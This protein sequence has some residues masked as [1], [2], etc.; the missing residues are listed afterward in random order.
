MLTKPSLPLAAMIAITLSAGIAT[1][2]YAGSHRPDDKAAIELLRKAMGPRGHN[3][4]FNHARAAFG[5]NRPKYQAIIAALQTCL[6]KRSSGYDVI[7]P[8]GDPDPDDRLHCSIGGTDE[9]I[10]RIEAMVRDAD[11]VN[12]AYSQPSSPDEPGRIRAANFMIFSV[13]FAG[14]GVSTSISF[15]AKE[16]SCASQKDHDDGVYIEVRPLTGPPCEWVWEHD[17]E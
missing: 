7:W 11:I 6:P 13:G 9:P 8:D 16:P 1:T 3:L 17:E 4:S 14:S 12:L 10:A 2:L 15:N 5:A